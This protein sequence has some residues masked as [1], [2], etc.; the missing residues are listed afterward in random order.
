MNYRNQFQDE[1]SKKYGIKLGFMSFFL[2]ASSIALQEFPVVNAVIDGN[3]II[4]RDFIDISVAVAAP[5]GLM[6]PIIRNC[7]NRGL[8]DFELVKKYSLCRL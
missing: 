4:Y 8:A 6:V 1:F 2:R 5:K 3:D 7:E